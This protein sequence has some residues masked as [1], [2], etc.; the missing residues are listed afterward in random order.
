[1]IVLFKTNNSTFLQITIL[2]LF[3]IVSGCTKTVEDKNLQLENNKAIVMRAWEECFNQGNTDLIDELFD[4]SYIE[5]T[6]YSLIKQGGPERVK[7]AFKWMNSVF[8]D[9][10]FE[11]EQM[12]AEGDKVVSRAMATGKHIGEFMG[13]SAT[14]KPV[15]FAAILPTFLPG[16]APRLTVY[17]LPTC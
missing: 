1:M 2:L 17:G 11:V 3:I 13:V 5:R 4:E 14:N 6:P 8:G 15:R 12:I 9:L 7:Q 16:G 10:H